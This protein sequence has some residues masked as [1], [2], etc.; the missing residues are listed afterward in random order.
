MFNQAFE[1]K[2]QEK[3]ERIFRHEREQ[4]QERQQQAQVQ[5]NVD[6]LKDDDLSMADSQSI[7]TLFNTQDVLQDHSSSD[8]DAGTDTDRLAARRDQAYLVAKQHA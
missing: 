5:A 2:I 4:E 8:G 7:H 3:Q 1:E 6:A